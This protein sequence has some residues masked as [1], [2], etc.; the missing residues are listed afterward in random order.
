MTRIRTTLIQVIRPVL[1]P[2]L[3]NSPRGIGPPFI[4]E[5]TASGEAG[6]T[7]ATSNLG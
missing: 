7:D 3:L 1:A 5:S 2:E 4:E 6:F